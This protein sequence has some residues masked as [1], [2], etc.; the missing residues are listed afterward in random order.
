MIYV[1]S[2]PCVVLASAKVV[3]ELLQKSM[4]LLIVEKGAGITNYGGICRHAL[5]WVNSIIIER[6][7]Q[8][9]FK[10]TELLYFGCY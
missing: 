10:K 5:T 1:K 8:V 7:N 6:S 3:D 2:Q 4:E 9:L